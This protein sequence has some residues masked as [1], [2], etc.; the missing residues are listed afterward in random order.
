LCFHCFFCKKKALKKSEKNKEKRETSG[1]KEKKRVKH[2][3]FD[4]SC[5]DLIREIPKERFSFGFIT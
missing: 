4:L 2:V 1:E 3:T 5:E